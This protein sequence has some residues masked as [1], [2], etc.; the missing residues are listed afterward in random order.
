M[1][2]PNM[3]LF[4][5]I[6]TALFVAV[7]LVSIILWVIESRIETVRKRAIKEKIESG[8]GL[9]VEDEDL[10]L[11][12]Q[13]GT[14]EL[15]EQIA[16]QPVVPAPQPEEEEA[17]VLPMEEEVAAA[18]EP[19]DDVEEQEAREYEELVSRYGEITD[20]SVIFESN[21]AEK[22]SFIEKYAELE[23]ATRNRYDEIV[24]YILGHKDCK[25]IEA[26][27]A[28]T[29]KCGTDKIM[30]AMIKRGVVILNF[31]LANTELNR[32][33][34]EEGI[35]KIKITPVSVRLEGDA[36]VALAKQM[37]DITIENLRE[38]QDY[39]KQR[40]KELRR[41]RYQQRQNEEK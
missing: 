41:M 27:H 10:F 40:R 25:K 17:P 20:R 2:G 35:K 39:R 18:E 13:N 15:L 8:K 19:A 7:L 21:Q 14:V 6:I 11:R 38:D 29:F 16:E 32:F 3:Q 1:N 37:A 5:I 23:P 9:R 31:M 12:V 30:R 28:V 24:A 22:K 4:F 33:V 36:D 26:A 34:R